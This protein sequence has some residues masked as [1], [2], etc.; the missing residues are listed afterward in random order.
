MEAYGSCRPQGLAFAV[1]G[2]I[3]RASNLLD[4]S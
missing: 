1:E 4:I 3:F 2:A